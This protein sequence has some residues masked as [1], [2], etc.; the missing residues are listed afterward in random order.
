M[1]KIIH[2]IRQK[3]YREKE[4]IA[5]LSALFI[6]ILIG[7]LWFSGTSTLNKTESTDQMANVNSPFE[8]IKSKFSLILKDYKIQQ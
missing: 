7:V 4:N 3:S 6:T 1:K 5:F 8:E 2:K